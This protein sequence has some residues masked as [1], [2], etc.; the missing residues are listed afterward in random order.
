[1]QLM[2]NA[3]FSSRSWYEPTNRSRDEKKSKTLIVNV[4]CNEQCCTML[5]KQIIFLL[6][7]NVDVTPCKK[8][9]KI[10]NL[11]DFNS[12]FFPFFAI[13]RFPK[14]SICFINS[15]WNPYTNRKYYILFLDNPKICYKLG[16]SSKKVG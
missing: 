12:I 1:M 8:N 15:P 5:Q 2:Q 6:S 11:L 9:R 10:N 7:F 13:S 14:I 3:F 4:L 16:T